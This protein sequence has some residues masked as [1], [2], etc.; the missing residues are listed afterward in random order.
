[1][2]GAKNLKRI[3]TMTDY[4]T[5]EEHVLFLTAELS[6]KENVHLS[7]LLLAKAAAR[8]KDKRSRR[9]LEVLANDIEKLEA[10][11]RE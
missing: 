8:I 3:N 11:V 6:V 9:M 10:E 2:A 7:Q 4:G 1:M 5:A